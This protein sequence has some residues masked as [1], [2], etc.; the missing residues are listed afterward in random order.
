MN[1]CGEMNT[2]SL[3][4]SA[5]SGPSRCGAIS[6]STYGAAAAKSQNDSAPYRWSSTEMARVSDKIPVT[7]DAAEKLPI[8]NGRSAWA[9]SASI[10]GGE[11]DP[12]VGVLGD[13]DD[14]GD[15]LAPGQLVRVVLVRPDEHH[16]P[17]ALRDV[18]S[19]AVA[20]VDVGRQSEVEARDERVDR[21]GRARAAE[22][23]RVLVR[24]AAAC[25]EDQ[26]AGVLAE[27][28]GLHAGARGLAV[29]VRV[30]RKHGVADVVLDRCERPSRRGVVRVRDPAETPRAHDGLVGADHRVPD[31]VEHR[32]IVRHAHRW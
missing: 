2:A 31:P 29:G 20:G 18:R 23:H 14:V 24:V 1:L 4:S 19:Q 25:L 27:P 28:G 7:F 11:V 3:W 10:E 22:E 9:A 16:R 30:Q 6:I 5:A 21:A 8:F 26:P 32:A 17:L 12:A 15:R 13:L